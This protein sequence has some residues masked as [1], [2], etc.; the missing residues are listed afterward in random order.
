MARLTSSSTNY[1]KGI[2][3]ANDIHFSHILKWVYMFSLAYNYALGLY[4]EFLR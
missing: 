1:A 2:I 3:L 4:V